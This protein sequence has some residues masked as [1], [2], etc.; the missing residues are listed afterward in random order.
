MYRAAALGVDG[1]PMTQEEL[2]TARRAQAIVMS[3]GGTTQAAQAAG[4]EAVREMRSRAEADRAAAY[5]AS[6]SARRAAQAAARDRQEAD[7]ATTRKEDSNR[8]CWIAG[9]IGAV[10]LLGGGVFLMRRSK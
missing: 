3:R 2:E 6:E 1:E 4:E 9:G 8:I 10:L 7:L 5:Q